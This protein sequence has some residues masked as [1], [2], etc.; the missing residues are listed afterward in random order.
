MN[1][2]DTNMS[3][4]TF[5]LTRR[6]LVTLMGVA[7]MATVADCQELP[8]DEAAR[9]VRMRSAND[10]GPAMW[11][12]GGVLLVKLNGHVAT[13]LLGMGGVAFTRAIQRSPGVFDWQLDEVGYYLDLETG[14]IVDSF[15]SPLNGETIRPAHYRAPE[16]LTFTDSNVAPQ[17]RLPS[18]IEFDGQITRLADVAG[19]AAMTEDMYVKIPASAATAENPARSARELSS[20][21][22]FTAK[23]DDLNATDDRWIDCQYTYTTMNSLASWLAIDSLAG[24]QNMRLAGTKC[25]LHAPGAIPEWFVT[26]VSK[27]HPDFLDAP[28]KWA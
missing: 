8:V 27:D 3:V 15:V 16:H 24:V 2:S 1:D 25:R 28:L 19:M 10:G 12:F 20:L 9:Y 18:G 23:T 11:V 4:Q 5:A 22:T 13:R 21:K 14:E 17:N 7:S 26:R 6:Q